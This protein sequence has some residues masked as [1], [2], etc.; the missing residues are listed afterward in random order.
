MKG[1]ILSRKKLRICAS[2]LIFFSLAL[3]CGSSG[4]CGQSAIEA[5]PAKS[6][7][8][9][10]PVFEVA[11]IKPMNPD[12]SGMLGFMSYPGGKVVVGNA[13]LKMLVS[14]AFNVEEFQIVDKTGWAGSN[15][16]N[17]VA[18]PA[19]DSPSEKQDFQKAEPNEVQ[20]EMLQA[21][22][23]ER[24]GL[25][26]HVEFRQGP[27]YIL[28]LGKKKL[29]LQEPK[30]KDSDPRG[31]VYMM[32]GGIADGTASGNNISM[33]FLATQLSPWLE[34]PVLDETGLTGSYDFRLMPD[35]P[36][37][38]DITAA[39]IHAMDRLGLQ[40]KAGKGPIETVVID[41]ANKPTEN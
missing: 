39:I 38:H 36:T 41:S 23:V 18:L 15:R 29:M 34:R 30:Y 6:Q 24:F 12:G 28:S 9:S 1:Y 7:N 4:M 37:N 3:L 22:L 19:S 14:Y 2:G 25:K 27:V 13:S 26:S 35:D 40:L 16:Y 10:K 5:K 17:I 33:K 11:T 21:L 8:L 20:R 32:A 31:G